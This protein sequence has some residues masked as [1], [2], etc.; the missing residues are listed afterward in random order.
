[1]VGSRWDLKKEKTS[2]CLHVP[3]SS[4]CFSFFFFLFFVHL[5]SDRTIQGFSSE[6]HTWHDESMQK[7]DA[8]QFAKEQEE[9][10][11]ADKLSPE[12]IKVRA[13]KRWKKAISIVKIGVRLGGS[14]GL[15]KSSKNKGPS[16]MDRIKQLEKD[17]TKLVI[18]SDDKVCGKS[19]VYIFLRKNT[20]GRLATREGGR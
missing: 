16:L 4:S 1:M 13:K 20:E 17:M 14:Q 9:H 6:L 3:F 11:E 7:W 19:S 8:A 10:P 2:C 15:L 18:Q 5:F 12:E